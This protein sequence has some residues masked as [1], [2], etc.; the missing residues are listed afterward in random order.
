MLPT[1]AVLAICLLAC[2]NTAVGSHTTADEL[3]VSSA[4]S[5]TL[6]PYKKAAVFIDT[7]LAELD[8]STSPGTPAAAV[9]VVSG[10]GKPARCAAQRTAAPSNCKAVHTTL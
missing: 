2:V 8:L 4:L 3:A 1:L 10:R 5:A 7:S 9:L 6:G